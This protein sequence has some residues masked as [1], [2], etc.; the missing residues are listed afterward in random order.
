MSGCSRFEVANASEGL[1]E[2]VRKRDE[3]RFTGEF[4]PD[5]PSA[6][7]PFWLK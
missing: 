6:D 2:R 4:A 5:L 7:H 3:T 1:A